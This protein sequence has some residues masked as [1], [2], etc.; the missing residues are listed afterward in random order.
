VRRLARGTGPLST[1]RSKFSEALLWGVS[2]DQGLPE[3]GKG[4]KRKQRGSPQRPGSP[5]LG[6]SNEEKWKQKLL[7]FAQL[8]GEQD[9]KH[10]C[11]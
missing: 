3:T 2:S 7:Y 8:R 6:R 5:G 9:Q 1:R 11:R 4:E 10:L